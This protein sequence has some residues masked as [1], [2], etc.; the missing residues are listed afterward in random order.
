[1]YDTP[2]GFRFSFAEGEIRLSDYRPAPLPD[3][4][5]WHVSRVSDPSLIDRIGL[6]PPYFGNL[7]IVDGPLTW[8][9]EL[10][11]WFCGVIFAIPCIIARCRH[12]SPHPP[13]VCR[14]CRYNLTANESGI[15]P[16][17]GTP[18]DAR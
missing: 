3:F 17:C 5:G 15:C 14:I 7:R 1:W 11:F 8:D 16:E 13:G 10:P 6:I 2:F 18:I 9:M 4:R 12:H